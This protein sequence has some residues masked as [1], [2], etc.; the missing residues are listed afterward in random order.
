MTKY[1]LE[2]LEKLV[3]LPVE[4]IE[5]VFTHCG[6]ALNLLP[7][8]RGS[9]EDQYAAMLHHN[10][11]FGEGGYAHLCGREPS[12]MVVSPGRPGRCLFYCARC[13]LADSAVV[14]KAF[15]VVRMPNFMG[16]ADEDLLES[17]NSLRRD[18]WNGWPTLF[19]YLRSME[20]W[21]ASVV[22]W[23]RREV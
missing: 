22:S 5:R 16:S 4:S 10:R 12:L 1:D 19:E 11:T 13:F 15:L 23:C 14:C 20:S 3:G 18:I 9:M 7:K 8:Y 6:Y 21:R 17:C 2:E